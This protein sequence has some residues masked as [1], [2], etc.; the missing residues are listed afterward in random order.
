[1][2]MTTA[3]P[4]HSLVLSGSPTMRNNHSAVHSGVLAYRYLYRYFQI[5][6]ALRSQPRQSCHKATTCS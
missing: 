1:M 3:P 2:I 4:M 6:V 5:W